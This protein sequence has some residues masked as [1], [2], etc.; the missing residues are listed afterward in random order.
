MYMKKKFIRKTTIQI[1]PEEIGQAMAQLEQTLDSTQA[2]HAE[3]VTAL[4]LAEELVPRMLH[5]PAQQAF[6][7]VSEFFGDV[8]LQ[9]VQFGGAM[10]PLE[11]SPFPEDDEQDQYRSQILSAY[12]S[13]MSYTRRNRRNIVSVAVHT[14]ANKQVRY[15]LLAMVLGIAVGLLMKSLL[16]ASAVDFINSNILVNI[17][18]M[19]LNALKMMIA[20]LVFFSVVSSLA[21][22]G[23]LSSV[24]RSGGKIMVFYFITSLMAAMVGLGLFWLFFR[25]QVPQLILGDTAN[26][27]EATEVDMIL[28]LKNIIPSDLVSPILKMDMLQVLFVSILFGAALGIMQ[29]SLGT[30]KQFALE[31][32]QLCTK[33]VN[34]IVRFLPLIAFVSMTS[35][36]IKVGGSTMLTLGMILLGHILGV[37]VT[38]LL[39]GLMITLMGRVAPMP[40]WRKVV[41]YMPIPFSLSS[42]NACIPLTLDFCEKKMGISPSLASFSI[43]IGSTI[44]MDGV[45]MSIV[46]QGLLLA[47]MSGLTITP[48]MVVTV[49]LTA[50]LLSVGAP[51]VAGSAFICLT[52]IVVTLGMPA[53]AATFVL[54]IDSILTMFRFTHNV[55]GDIAATTAVAA[56][57]QQMNRTVYHE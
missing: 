18:S 55:T 25:G 43:P 35:L 34:M 11:D 23:S 3:T 20:P 31:M 32:N 40:F 5:E 13:R 39:Y 33:V 14:A 19:F 47:K 52:T 54:G 38:T 37:V 36:I 50:L 16:P 7:T 57:D 17:R 2:E 53:E 41:R 44:N 56:S 48:G 1:P 51:G 15:T 49:V 46:F 42:S 9:I 27:V 21:G 10:N 6:I 22:L 28:L 26:A 29:D 4:L 8:T 30:V 45:C 12:R 24:G